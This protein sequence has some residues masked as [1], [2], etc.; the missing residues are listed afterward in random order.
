MQ[1]LIYDNFFMDIIEPRVEP[2]SCRI[3]GGLAVVVWL[4]QILGDFLSGHGLLV[5]HQLL[6]IGQGFD[7]AVGAFGV[8]V[9]AQFFD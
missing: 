2:A 1:H 8:A 7:L 4:I 6:Q 5:L 3:A 9:Y